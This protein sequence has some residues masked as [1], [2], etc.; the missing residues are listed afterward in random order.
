M[1]IYT[2][3]FY[4]SI[5]KNEIMWFAGR[6]VELENFMLSKVSQAQKKSKISYFLS[7]VEARPLS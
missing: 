6:W 4:S 5:K 3:K 1:Y 2:M 7:Y